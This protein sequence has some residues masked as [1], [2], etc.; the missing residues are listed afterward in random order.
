MK[1]TYR[2]EIDG[3]RA[4]AVLLVIFYHA[5]ITV[6]GNNFFKAGFIGVDIFFVISG[7]LIT[8]L[9]L[10]ELKEKNKFSFLHF[11]ERRARRILPALFFVMLL[12]IPFAWIYLLPS[13]FVDY[14]KSILYSIGFTSNF[15]FHFSG[16]EYGSPD[17]L[18]KPFLH[19]WSLSV[20]EQY[21]II[22]PAALIICFK[23]LKKHILTILILS[24]V[25]SL[26]IADWGSK[27]YPSI[28]FYLL[29]SRMWELLA[30]SILS[31]FEVNYGRKIKN[32]F[33]NNLIPLF[34][35]V[36]IFSYIFF[37]NER[38][39]HPSFFTIIPVLGVC[40]LI[41]FSNKN[42]LITKILSSKLFVGTGLISYSL[43]LWHFP[44]FAFARIKD[45]T[46]SQYDKFEWIFLTIVLSVLTY[47]LIEKFFKNRI[48]IS[49]KAL[50]FSLSSVLLLVFIFN[51]Y[52]IYKKGFDYKYQINENYTLD[53]DFYKKQWLGFVKKVGMPEFKEK[54]KIKV[55]IIGNSHGNDTFNSFY[56]NKNLFDKHEFSIIN[57][58]VACFYYFVINEKL[59][60]Y[61]RQSFSGKNKSLAK[62]LFQKSDLLIISTQWSEKDIEILEKLISEMKVKKKEILLFNNSLEV[63]VKIR[64]GFHILDFFVFRNGR[65][66]NADELT[67]IENEMFKQIKNKDKLNNKLIKIAKNK[68]IKILLKEEYLCD[69]DKKKCSVFT[70]D[71]KKISWD[72][73]HYTLE[74]AKYLG[75]KI[76]ENKW[77]AY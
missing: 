19:T 33:L 36:L 25:I 21:Y 68:D 6:L 42:D 59:P 38:I 30:G 71:Y 48:A 41:W 47:F 69:L 74:G 14:S 32:N 29:H 52:I 50:M 16:L 70:D 27:N 1:L 49:K 51:S 35:L 13:N 45:N 10:K 22:F 11:Y 7:Y 55:L 46:P 65:L 63:N 73:A 28:T 62:S 20:E 77:F 31:Y 34:G 44:I 9:I 37:Y 60:L 39:T 43:Y 57:V 76:Y 54:G 4:I 53:N 67:K 24:M 3:L 72:Y 5:E 40:L 17:G 26:I 58:H 8:S 75:K 12:T 18:F 56:L 2:P 15:Y 23:Y 66:P 64:R 61:C